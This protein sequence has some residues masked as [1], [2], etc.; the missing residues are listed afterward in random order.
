MQF[1]VYSFSAVICFIVAGASISAAIFLYSY[2]VPSIVGGT[3]LC[4][5]PHWTAATI[6]LA[7]GVLFSISGTVL[8][9][10]AWVTLDPERYRRLRKTW[11]QAIS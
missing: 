2:C 5:Y 7:V 8:G 1:Y 9:A 6:I 11:G 3:L 10:V 4:V